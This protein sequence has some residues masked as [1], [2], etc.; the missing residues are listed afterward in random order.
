M[1]RTLIFG[2]SGGVGQALALQEAASGSQL[3]LVHHRQP[4]EELQTRSGSAGADSGEAVLA[5]SV[6]ASASID[7]TNADEVSKVFDHADEIGFATSAVCNC[8]GSLHLKPAHLT[9]DDE[10]YST[11]HTNLSSSFFILRE[12]ARRCSRPTSLVFVSTAATHIGL[13]NHE[14]I[15]AAK[16]GIE[17]MLR[18]AASGYASKG[19]RVNAVAPG[20]VETPLT[21]RITSNPSAR[22]TSEKMHALGRIGTPEDIA[23][24][25]SFLLSEQSSWITGQVLPVDGGLSCLRSR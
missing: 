15:A 6:Q 14:A 22:E 20:L 17:A 24:A 11:L 16:G 21:S 8:I 2:A 4:E 12:T 13:P 23:A 18:S 10:W 3:Y 9:K 19:L 25:I 1:R 7:A 5:R